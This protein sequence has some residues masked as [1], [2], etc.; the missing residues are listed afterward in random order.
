MRARKPVGTGDG[1]ARITRKQDFPSWLLFKLDRPQYS[2]SPE[3]LQSAL[4]WSLFQPA[5]DDPLV[6]VCRADPQRDEKR[7]KKKPTRETTPAHE[8]ELRAQ[9]E[10]AV[11]ARG[12]PADAA[13][14]LLEAIGCRERG[15]LN[16]LASPISPALALLQNPAGAMSVDN[17]PNFANIIET[18]LAAGLGHPQQIAGRRHS[19]TRLPGS[20]VSAF[21]WSTSWTGNSMRSGL[22]RW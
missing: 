14:L 21:R 1:K 6:F 13:D 8:P 4:A 7:R 17:P 10:A 16:Q 15:D 22:A 18:C 19:G 11:K 20:V 9:W 5:S 12:F 3:V 2:P